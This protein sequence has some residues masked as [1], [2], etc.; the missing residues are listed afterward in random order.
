MATDPASETEVVPKEVA[1][2]V[3]EL[4]DVYSIGDLAGD[5]RDYYA[6]ESPEDDP[7]HDPTGERSSWDHPKVKRF[8]EG[9]EILTRWARTGTE[10]IG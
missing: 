10:R 6:G 7:D 9:V 8:G 2:F 4:I 3:R 5:Y 1:D